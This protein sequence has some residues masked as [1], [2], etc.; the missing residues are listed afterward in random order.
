[1]VNKN[2]NKKHH[3]YRRPKLSKEELEKHIK[4]ARSKRLDIIAGKIIIQ[5]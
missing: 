5:E 1:M 3:G 4:T 2:L